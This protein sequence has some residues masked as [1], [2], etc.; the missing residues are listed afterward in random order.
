MVVVDVE[1]VVVED[2][3]VVAA[4]GGVVGT[5]GVT[6]TVGR[7]WRRTR[8]V[9]VVAGGGSV[10]GGAVEVVAVVGGTVDVVE[11]RSG[12]GEV[13]GAIE[14]TGAGCADPPLAQARSG[15]FGTVSRSSAQQRKGLPFFVNTGLNFPSTIWRNE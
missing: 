11:G 1:V 3:V 10:V 2:E 4:V 7:P 8:V 15:V 9:G 6:M 12:T 5:V 13:V 14:R